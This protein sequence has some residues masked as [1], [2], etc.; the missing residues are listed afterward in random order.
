M[1][2]AFGGLALE[3]SSRSS[4]GGARLAEQSGVMVARAIPMSWVTW[5]DVMSFLVC[6][7]CHE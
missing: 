2:G 6:G 7:Q 3:E 1:Q 5:D 4:I